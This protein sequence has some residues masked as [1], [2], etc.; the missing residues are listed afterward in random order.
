[1]GK[2]SL[3]MSIV[4]KFLLHVV[5]GVVRPVRVLWNEII[6][7]VFICFTVLLAFNFVRY[8]REYQGDPWDFFRLVVTASFAL[9]M[10]W[11]GLSSFRRAKRISR[12]Q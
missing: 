5:P 2:V 9:L 4:R 1:M 8:W 12:S 7:F 11:Y 10:A 6:G 3:G